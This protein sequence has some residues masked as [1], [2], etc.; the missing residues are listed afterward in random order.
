MPQPER[1]KMQTTNT[2]TDAAPGNGPTFEP[3][4]DKREVGRRTQMRPRTIDDWMQRGLLPYYKVGRSVRF[5]WS[6]VETHL[7]TNCRI[8]NLRLGK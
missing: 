3:Y 8:C 4:I 6:E 2:P 5:K 1:L 7:A